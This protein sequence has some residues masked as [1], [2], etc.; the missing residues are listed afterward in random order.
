MK[1]TIIIALTGLLLGCGIDKEVYHTDLARL[2]AQI[3]QLEREKSECNRRFGEMTQARDACHREL[4]A[5]KSQGSSLSEGLKKALRR[6]DELEQIAAK[7]RA[8]FD[9][10]RGALDALVKAG[11]LSIAIVRGQFTVQMAD[12]ILFD[13]GQYVLKAEAEGTLKELTSIL[14]SVPSRLYQVAGHTDT[15]GGTDYN[16][17]LSVNR[18]LAVLFFMIKEGMPPERISTAGYGEFQPTAPNDTK[19][20]KALNRRIEVVLIPDMEEFMAPFKESN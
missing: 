4:A 2:K 9:K 14:A 10:L 11:K 18:S 17:R 19:E 13:S 16:W 1:T 5:I 12:K 8:V 3:D 6:I 20:S 7:Q 15:D